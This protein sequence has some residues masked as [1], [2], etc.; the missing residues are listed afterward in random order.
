MLVMGY[1]GYQAESVRGEGVRRGVGG[2]ALLRGLAGEKDGRWK[3]D[4]RSP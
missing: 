3:N 1:R 2:V 4:Q